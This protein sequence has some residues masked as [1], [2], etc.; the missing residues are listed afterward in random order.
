MTIY[1]LKNRSEDTDLA[2]A[3]PYE[4][5]LDAVEF[6]PIMDYHNVN[7]EELKAALTNQLRYDGI[8]VTSQRAVDAMKCV[9]HEIPQSILSKH[10]YTVGP[11]TAKRLE[12]LNF[13]NVQG[14][15]SGNGIALASHMIAT[16]PKGSKFLF[17]A[18]EIHRRQ[19]PDRL[20]EAGHSVTTSI[21]YRTTPNAHVGELIRKRVSH[22]DW[23]VFFS[24]S[25]T[26]EVLEALRTTDKRIHLAAIGP[27]THTFLKESG[28]SV[29]AIAPD[30]TAHGLK[31]A[32]E[33]SLQR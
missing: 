29:N 6:I 2:R 25:H 12:A 8:I 13:T 22:G 7:V 15:D 3:D 21:V 5:A 14:S 18:G 32:I 17:L 26:H 31:Q 19:L 4:K 20:M 11:T 16:V 30:P 27:T 23:I 10:I 28:F 9:L 1:L 24:P 33:Q